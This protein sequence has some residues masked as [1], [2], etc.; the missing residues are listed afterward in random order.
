MRKKSTF[1]IVAEIVTIT[2]VFAVIFEVTLLIDTPWWAKI[3][4]IAASA[5]AVVIVLTHSKKQN[6]VLSK[7]DDQ[8]NQQN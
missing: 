6:N 1:D 2:I 5:I 7:R 4:P 3:A 8:D